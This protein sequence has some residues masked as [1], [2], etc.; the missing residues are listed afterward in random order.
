MSDVSKKCEY[1]KYGRLTADKGTVLCAKKGPVAPDYHCR[2]Y[3][4][5]IL[6][7]EPRKAN[8]IEPINPDDF[9]L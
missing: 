9:K 4:Y 5:D 2:K 3:K 7:R 1:C 8:P 6:K